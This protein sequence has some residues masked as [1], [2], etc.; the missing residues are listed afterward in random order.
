MAICDEAMHI[1][2]SRLRGDRHDLVPIAKTQQN[3]VGTLVRVS[4]W[5]LLWQHGAKTLM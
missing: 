1:C 2:I 3:R 5:L 4:G